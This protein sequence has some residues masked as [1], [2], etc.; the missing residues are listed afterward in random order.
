MNCYAS[1]LSLLSTTITDIVPLKLPL[2]LP[3]C[4]FLGKWCRYTILSVPPVGVNMTIPTPEPLELQA[5]STYIVHKSE[6][7][8][9]MDAT[10]M[11]ALY[12]SLMDSSSVHS[13]MNSTR[14]YSFMTD[15]GLQCISILL[16][17]M[18]I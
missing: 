4:L 7:G 11:D 18:A 16:S 14:A 3:H 13:M 6:V 2:T 8:T 1:K 17:L 15:C 12:N 9:P 10:S 5:P